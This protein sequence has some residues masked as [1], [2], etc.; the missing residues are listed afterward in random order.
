MLNTQFV[1]KPSPE[2][3]WY[4]SKDAVE[5]PEKSIHQFFDTYSLGS[6]HE[7][8]WKMLK[9][10]IGSEEI[11]EWDEIKRTNLIYFF[12]LLTELLKANYVLFFK[13][14]ETTIKK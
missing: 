8:L 4:L 5:H 12:E 10:T 13:M 2:E 6:A 11:N 9:F 1:N 14:R 3:L 7:R